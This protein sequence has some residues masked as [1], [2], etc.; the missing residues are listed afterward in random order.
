MPH[1]KPTGWPFVTSGRRSRLLEQEARI[2]NLRAQGLPMKRRDV[3]LQ[4]QTTLDLMKTRPDADPQA[5]T[6]SLFHSPREQT[7][8]R[9]PSPTI[10]SAA[11]SSSRTKGAVSDAPSSKSSRRKILLV[12]HLT[13][14]TQIFGPILDCLRLRVSPLFNRSGT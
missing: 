6:L 9:R 12:C 10:S 3:L 2:G 1:Q 11:G 14:A 8:R 7:G 5:G 4:L 13:A